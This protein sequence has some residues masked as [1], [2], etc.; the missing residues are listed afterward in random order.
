MPAVLRDGENLT[1][2]HMGEKGVREGAQTPGRKAQG[3]DAPAPC[4]LQTEGHIWAQY[5]STVDP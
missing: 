1:C 3:T 2:G 5:L 4:L